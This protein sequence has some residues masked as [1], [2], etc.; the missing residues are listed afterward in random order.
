MSH[1]SFVLW[2]I[3]MHTLNQNQYDLFFL[4]HCTKTKI[5]L[6]IV[7]INSKFSNSISNVDVMPEECRLHI[8]SK[9]DTAIMHNTSIIY[10]PKYN[11]EGV[12]CVLLH[13]C[14]TRKGQ[15]DEN[16]LT[17]MVINLERVLNCSTMKYIKKWFWYACSCDKEKESW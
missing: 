8:K 7:N 10:Q 5:S 16:L 11:H 9:F 15:P 2:L 12:H 6:K 4:C 13:T 1:F 17:L 14:W 3:P